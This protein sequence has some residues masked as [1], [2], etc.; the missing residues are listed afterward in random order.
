MLDDILDP[1]TGKMKSVEHPLLNLIEVS[2]SMRNVR[3][4]V[5]LL[6]HST[7]PMILH[8]D[9]MYCLICSIQ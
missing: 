6:S 2:T 4:Y 1:L 5:A 9:M 7:I 8:G 3:V